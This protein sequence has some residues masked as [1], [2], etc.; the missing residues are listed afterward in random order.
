MSDRSVTHSTFVIKRSYPVKPDRVFAAFAD[1]VKKRRWFMGGDGRDVEEFEMDFRVGGFE[2]ARSRFKPGTRFE[3]VMLTNETWYQDIVPD[4][5][6]VIAYTMSLEERRFSAS[7]A[8]IELVPVDT[9]S[10]LIFTEQGAYFEGSD[11]PQIRE[12]GW[13]QLLEQ[14]AGEFER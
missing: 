4:S 10:E 5:R 2:R 14:L 13:R 12:E 9:G 1:P 8:T 3:G 6:I 7:L 11:G